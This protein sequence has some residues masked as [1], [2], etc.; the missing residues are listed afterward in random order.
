MQEV[1]RVLKPGGHSFIIDAYPYHSDFGRLARHAYP[2][3][4][5]TGYSQDHAVFYA[6]KGFESYG[7]DTYLRAPDRAVLKHIPQIDYPE[8]YRKFMADIN[9]A[10]LTYNVSFYHFRKPEAL[11]TP[12]SFPV[13][14]PF[15]LPAAFSTPPWSF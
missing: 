12:R 11:R 3:T 9:G 2:T 7:V 14:V 1:Q 15:R 13:S 10:E 8:Q 6:E 5:R 4:F